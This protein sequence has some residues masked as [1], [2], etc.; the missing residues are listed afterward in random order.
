MVCLP[1]LA[2]DAGHLW[3]ENAPERVLRGIQVVDKRIAGGTM[4]LGC[5]LALRPESSTGVLDQGTSVNYPEPLP[6]DY[7]GTRWLGGGTP[8]L[9]FR[10]QDMDI[11]LIVNWEGTSNVEMI[12]GS[13]QVPPRVFHNDSG[14]EIGVWDDPL[15]NAATVVEAEQLQSVLAD[16]GT[17]KALPLVT[18][19]ESQLVV[20][21]DSDED[22]LELWILEL[23]PPRLSP[24]V[25]L[26][27]SG[28][29]RE[30]FPHA[31]D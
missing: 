21:Y 25:R 19:C 18:G 13:G 3:G 9:I 5:I 27:A 4:P 7:T 26:N 10:G 6:G 22:R 12:I 16:F 17:S 23:Y 11:A 20:E 28:F 1:S 24:S 29:Q 8:L 30:L 2:L 14:Q 15:P 31:N